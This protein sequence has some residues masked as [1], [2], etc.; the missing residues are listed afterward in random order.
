MK[1]NIIQ[2]FIGFFGIL[3]LLAVMALFCFGI[4]ML[5]IVI[6]NIGESGQGL[7]AIIWLLF[8]VAVAGGLSMVL[9]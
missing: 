4:P 3:L 6:F 1:E 2:F 5:L 7:L 9:D 8:L